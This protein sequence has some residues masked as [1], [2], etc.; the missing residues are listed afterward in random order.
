[1]HRINEVHVFH[2]F[3]CYS[4][5]QPE[6]RAPFGVS[7][8]TQRH[9]VGL[10]WTSDQPVTETYLYLHRITQETKC[11][12]R[13][14]FEPMISATKRPVGSAVHVFSFMQRVSCC[15]THERKYFESVVSIVSDYKTRRPGFDSEQVQRI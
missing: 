6:H 12:T 7:V 10:L 2:S 9:T 11:I 1:M 3:S 15:S 13:T 8:I 5:S 14:E 4:S